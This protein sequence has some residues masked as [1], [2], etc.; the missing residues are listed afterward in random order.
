MLTGETDAGKSVG[1]GGRR[2]GEGW[3]LDRLKRP[4]VAAYLLGDSRNRFTGKT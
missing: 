4:D 3:T 1:Q 2:H